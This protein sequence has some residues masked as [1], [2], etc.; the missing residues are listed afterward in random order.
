MFAAPRRVLTRPAAGA[1][2]GSGAQAYVGSG[3]TVRLVNRENFGW[4]ERPG[5]ITLQHITTETLLREYLM[6]RSAPRAQTPAL[7]QSVS[8]FKMNNPLNSAK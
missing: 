2:G 4:R 8:S 5:E 6:V 1:R 3:T 7:A